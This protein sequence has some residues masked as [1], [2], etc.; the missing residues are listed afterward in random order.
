MCGRV[1]AVLAACERTR[2]LGRTSPTPSEAELIERVC[3]QA[4][5]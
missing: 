3:L 5:Q 2:L 4:Y 1:Q